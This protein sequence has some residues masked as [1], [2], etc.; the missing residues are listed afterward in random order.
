MARPAVVK[1]SSS[2]GQHRSQLF[3]FDPGSASCGQ[4][5]L[6]WR[7]VQEPAIYL[8]PSISIL[9]HAVSALDH[10]HGSVKSITSQWSLI[11]DEWKNA[12]CDKV[13]SVYRKA[14]NTKWRQ[15]F[16]W[17]E[18]IT[19]RER[20]SWYM[21]HIPKGATWVQSPPAPCHPCAQ[22]GPCWKYH[23]PVSFG[24]LQLATTW[25]CLQ[26]LSFWLLAVWF[27]AADCVVW[28]A[29]CRVVVAAVYM[30]SQIEHLCGRQQRRS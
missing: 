1:N 8:R 20:R 14:E 16:I 18:C 29:S 21:Y 7:Q 4:K 13:H 26:A 25:F 3:V 15:L 30:F 24:R 19:G 6:L 12:K 17:N 28:A 2:G 9:E 11:V 5:F 10:R 22:S 23:V 27:W